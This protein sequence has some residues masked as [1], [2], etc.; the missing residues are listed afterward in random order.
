M[1]GRA[2]FAASPRVGGGSLLSALEVGHNDGPW[3]RP[4]NFRTVNGLVRYTRGDTSHGLSLTAMGYRARWN[5]TDQVPQRAIDSGLIGRFG[6]LDSTDGG[7][8]YRYSGSLEW[9]RS[10]GNA[11]TRVTAYGI[12]YDLDLFSNFTFYLDDPD[13]GDQFEQADHRFITGAK[14]SH[15][16]LQRWFGRSVQN[17]FGVQLRNDNITSGL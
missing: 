8:T 7:E 13:R 11:A 14:V 1:F 12:G 2:L 15:R 17:T 10:R 3:D 9:Q 4:D 16:R 5:S 6:A